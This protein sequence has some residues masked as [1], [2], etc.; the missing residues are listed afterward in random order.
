MTFICKSFGETLDF[1]CTIEDGEIV[2]QE[3][4]SSGP[5][6]AVTFSLDRGA[7]LDADTLRKLSDE[8]RVAQTGG[9]LR[10]VTEVEHDRFVAEAKAFINESNFIVPGGVVFVL[11]EMRANDVGLTI[12]SKRVTPEPP[13]SSDEGTASDMASNEDDN[14][15]YCAC[16]CMDYEYYD[17]HDQPSYSLDR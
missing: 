5:D 14:E 2:K 10:L 15:C 11:A 17:D 7:H 12:Y 4:V 8:I 9:R 1:T 3:L 13:K 6:A 16:G